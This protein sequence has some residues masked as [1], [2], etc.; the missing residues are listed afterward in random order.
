[1]DHKASEAIRTFVVFLCGVLLSV[2]AAA[3]LEYVFGRNAPAL[4][5]RLYTPIPPDQRALF[6]KQ[7]FHFASVTVYVVDPLVGV[8]VGLFVG[9]LQRTHAMTVAACCLIPDFMLGFVD[10]TRKV[11][12]HSVRGISIYSFDHALPF[13]A[14]MVTAAA[15]QYLLSLRHRATRTA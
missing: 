1:M 15:C 12:A 5:S 9:L 7:L 10:D 11:W 6:Y 2:V 4:I 14:A 3:C 13:A 8:V